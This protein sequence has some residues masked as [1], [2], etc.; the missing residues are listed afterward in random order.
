[1]S[2]PV[3]SVPCR[4][5]T[6]RLHATADV[7]V[8]WECDRLRD[9]SHVHDLSMAG[10]F[11]ETRR[12]RPKGDLVHIHFLV[13]E[14]Q[15]RLDGIVVRAQPNGLGLRIQA[16]TKEDIPQLTGLIDR[17]RSTPLVAPVSCRLFDFFS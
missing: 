9:I 11:I 7:W 16:V 17:M 2:L 12:G 6:M 10:L 5:R 4:R 15:I 3:R 13:A 14:G 1:V 8:Y